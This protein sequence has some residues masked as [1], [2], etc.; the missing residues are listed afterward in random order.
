MSQSNSVTIRHADL[1]DVKLLVDLGARTFE[2][3]FADANTPEDMAAYLT[4]N[5]TLEKLTAELA[6]VDAF[7]FIAEVEQVAAGYAKLK[8]GQLPAGVTDQQT[9]ELERLY[10]LPEFFGKGV[11]QALMDTCLFEASRLGYHTIWLGVW[12]HNERARAFYRKC[13]FH[14]VGEKIFQLG[15]DPQ[16]D[17]VMQR[18]L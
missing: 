9:I 11:G 5:F 2:R 18:T 14:E 7:F 3:A 10:T 1:A 12:E 17:K 8:K 13:G 15:S 16:T 6:D 4:T